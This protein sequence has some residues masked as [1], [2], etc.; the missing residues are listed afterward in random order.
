MNEFNEKEFLDKVEKAANKGA[1]KAGIKNVLLSLL[2]ILLAI[3]LLAYFIVPKINAVANIF[4]VEEDVEGH[5][6]TLENFGIFGYKAVD[7]QEAVLGDNSKLKKLEVYKQEVSDATTTTEAGLFK[8]SVFSKNQVITYKG[9]AI[10]TVD[11]SK[12]K[13]SDIELDEENKVVTIYIPHAVQEEIN[14]LEKD[15]SYSDVEKGL[16]AIGDIKMTPQQLSEIQA[17][18]RKKMQEKLDEQKALETADRFAKL[19][20][21]ELYS[22]IIK[23]VSKN[24]SLEVEFKD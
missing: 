2:P 9:T 18:A 6:L 7:F 13:E 24:Y 14:I 16:L 21:W 22:P 5:D 8:L 19:S 12:L 23:G 4:K 17:G 1:S 15:I 20:V 10:Y 11:L 3:G